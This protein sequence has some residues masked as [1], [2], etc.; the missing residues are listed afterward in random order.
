MLL[1]ALMAFEEI[2]EK[3]NTHGGVIEWR[4]PTEYERYVERLQQAAT[5][6]AHE[7]RQLRHIHHELSTS[8]VLLMDIDMLKH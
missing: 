8:V 4:T 7:N 5:K 3:R 1:N 6:L 2:V